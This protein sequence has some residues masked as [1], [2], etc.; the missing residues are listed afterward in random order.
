[1]TVS[2]NSVGN[3]QGTLGNTC[4]G[5]SDMQFSF[6][7]THIQET[8]RTCSDAQKHDPSETYMNYD[9]KKMHVFID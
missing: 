8:E 4:G 9:I 3:A 2:Q 1:M 6:F 7:R 5:D